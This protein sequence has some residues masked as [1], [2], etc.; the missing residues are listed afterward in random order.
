MMT[1]TASRSRRIYG[2]FH[3]SPCCDAAYA[4][5][6]DTRIPVCYDCEAPYDPET[7]EPGH[8]PTCDCPPCEEQRAVDNFNDCSDAFIED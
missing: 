6:E 8:A 3:S 7:G 5:D 2:A 4:L 1:A